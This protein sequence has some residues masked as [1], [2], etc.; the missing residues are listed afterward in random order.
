MLN[1]CSI[2]PY[3]ENFACDAEKN[4]GRCVDVNGA[5]VTATTG[6]P[7]GYEMT[8]DGGA[9]AEAGRVKDAGNHETQVSQPRQTYTDYRQSVYAKLQNMVESPQTPMV[10]PPEV[11]RTLIMNYKTT[12]SGRPLFMPRFVYFFATDPDWVIGEKEPRV[13]ENRLLNLDR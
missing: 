4:F 7:E 13:E 1:G 10:K 6:N 9:P 8:E 12:A 11:V 2:F 5:Y 3:E